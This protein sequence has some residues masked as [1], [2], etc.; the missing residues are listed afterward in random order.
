MPLKI[1][2]ANPNSSK[3]VTDTLDQLIS[4]PPG[5]DIT[6]FTG[7]EGAPPSINDEETS[8]QSEQ[9]CFNVL[10]TQ[11][12][13]FDAI[14]VACYSDHPLVNSLRK[15]FPGKPIIGIFEAS[16]AHA[17]L[18]GSKFGI[19]TTGQA[20]EALLTKGVAS[21]F[22]DEAPS[23]DPASWRNGRFAGVASTGFT[24]IELH[25]AHPDEVSR[26]I[27]EAAKRLVEEEDAD[28]ICLG[29]AGMTGMEEAIRKGVSNQ[30]I[31]IIDGV[32][33][34]VDL[35]AGLARRRTT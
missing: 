34:G 31:E 18:R 2:V 14:L 16:V 30:S 6:F 15:Q 17:L 1:L 13:E 29:C 28:V 10:K 3:S 24:A 19:V 4:R 11:G 5:C 20:W 23:T 26:K 32:Q 12:Q 9:A 7:P 8:V 35:L 25:Q 27:G 21:F 33:A 22:G